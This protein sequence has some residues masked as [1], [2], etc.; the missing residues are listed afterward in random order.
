MRVAAEVEGGGSPRQA[1]DE[2]PEVELIAV[3]PT[4]EAAEDAT[5]EMD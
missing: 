5:P 1:V 3:G 2:L 4:A